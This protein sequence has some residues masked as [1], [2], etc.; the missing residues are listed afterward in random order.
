MTSSSNNDINRK[1]LK[2]PDQFTNIVRRFFI[3]M[4][5]HSRAMLIALGVVFII[6]VVGALFLQQRETNGIK[7]SGALFVARQSLEKQLL[8]IAETSAPDKNQDKDKSK[9]KG[10]EEK[11]S[12]DSIAHKK[13]DVDAVLADSVA[14]IKSVAK[15]YSGTRA[16]FDAQIMLGDLYFNHGQPEKS[17]A[18]YKEAVNQATGSFDKMLSLYSLGYAYENTAKYQDAVQA[19]DRAINLGDFGLKG[20][21]LLGI[22]RCY[23]ATRDLAKARSTY[24]QVIAQFPTSTYSKTAEFA[25]S[26]I[27]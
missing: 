19:Y 5:K 17:V 23:E 11:P 3:E 16:A 21:L 18:W 13:L 22:G 6:G 10:K 20:D 1:D 25:K 24:D 27:E 12:I 7:A 9:D 14:K 4:A 26:R 2:Q 15:D 8:N